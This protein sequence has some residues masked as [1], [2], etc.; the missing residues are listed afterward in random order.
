MQGAGVCCAW[1]H[2]LGLLSAMN[3]PKNKL[4]HQFAFL[5]PLLQIEADTKVFLNIT[6][7][8]DDKLGFGE[9][10]QHANISLN[11][12]N[13][14]IFRVLFALCRLYD[15]CTGAAFIKCCFSKI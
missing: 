10:K 4:I 11:Y 12:V 15:K 5:Q 13:I 2:C 3:K 7:L 14:I 9:K 6:L 8:T 1:H